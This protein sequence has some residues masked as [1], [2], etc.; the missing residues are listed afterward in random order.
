MSDQ[1]SFVVEYKKLDDT[2][3]VPTRAHPTDT[4][5]DISI[6]GVRKNLSDRTKLYGTGLVVKPP[7]GYYIEIVARSSL[8]KSGYMISNSIGIIDEGYRGELMVALTKVDDAFP[9]LKLPFRCAQIKLVKLNLYDLK[10]TIDIDKTQRGN[11][12]F[13]SSDKK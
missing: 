5:Y 4:G 9:D 11:K 1:K 13:G 2:A 10:E 3:L 6:I 8:S 12:G 7:D